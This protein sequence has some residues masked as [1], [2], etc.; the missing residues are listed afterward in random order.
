MLHRLKI[1][2]EYAVA[3]CGGAKMFEIRKEDDRHFDIGDV[4][5]FSVVDSEE[6]NEI[7]G[8]AYFVPYVLRHS[9]FPDAIKKGYCAFTLAQL[10][11]DL[12][13]Y[14]THD[15]AEDETEKEED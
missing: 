7:E 10:P 4:V 1:K 15:M 11:D 14:Y 12:A 5:T 6:Y 9:D 3:I 2:K 13:Y 8:R